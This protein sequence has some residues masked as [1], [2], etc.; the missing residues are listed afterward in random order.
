MHATRKVHLANDMIGLIIFGGEYK[1]QSPINDWY[2]GKFRTVFLIDY[3]LKL[4]TLKLSDHTYIYK[5]VEGKYSQ[6][7]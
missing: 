6:K 7:L 2:K 3:A 5:L 1:L 4:S